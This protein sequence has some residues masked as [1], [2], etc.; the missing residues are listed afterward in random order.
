MFN[1][2]RGFYVQNV[3]FIGAVPA[4]SHQGEEAKDVLSQAKLD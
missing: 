2:I 4:V 1:A 3:V